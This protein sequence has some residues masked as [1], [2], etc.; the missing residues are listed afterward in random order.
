MHICVISRCLCL[1]FYWVWSFPLSA[2][3][4]QVSQLHSPSHWQRWNTVI[5]QL[6]NYVINNQCQLKPWKNLKPKSQTQLLT[7]RY[8][9]LY[10]SD[11]LLYL[12]PSLSLFPSVYFHFCDCCETVAQSLMGLSVVFDW[13]GNRHFALFGHFLFHSHWCNFAICAQDVFVPEVFP[14]APVKK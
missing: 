9:F 10:L 7:P 11:S 12:F 13:W 4:A 5:S 2:V 6:I 14:S 8:L 3:C 1:Q